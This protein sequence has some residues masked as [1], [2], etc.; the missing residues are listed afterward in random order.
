ML[1]SGNSAHLKQRDE[2]LLQDLYLVRYLTTSQIARMYFLM[3]DET[4]QRTRA[5]A[6]AADRRMYRL[7]KQGWLRNHPELRSTLGNTYKLWVLSELAFDRERREM[8]EGPEQGMPPAPKIGRLD[9]LVHIND[10]YVACAPTLRFFLGEP[11]SDGSESWTWRYEGKHPRQI[12]GSV[13]EQKLRPD[14][15]IQVGQTT[16]FVEYQSIQ[17][18]V[19]VE[20]IQAKTD[21]YARYV[22]RVLEV[23]PDQ[24]QLLMVTDQP[25]IAQATS[26][27]ASDLGLHA[28]CGDIEAINE[29][30]ISWVQNI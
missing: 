12:T 13:H 5:S 9:H 21:N 7:S 17:S 11:D 28:R 10:L 23:P 24:A 22:D 1:V 8:G 6:S 27:R 25:R 15:E 30:L 29:Y 20:K 26:Q 16:F 19:T 3:P 2:A 18:R 4:G 14:A